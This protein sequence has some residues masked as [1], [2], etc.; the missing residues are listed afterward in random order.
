MGC[1]GKCNNCCIALDMVVADLLDT[2]SSILVFAY[3]HLYVHWYVHS[4]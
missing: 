1:L 2:L 3:V 4:R